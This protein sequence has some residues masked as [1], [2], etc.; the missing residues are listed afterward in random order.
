LGVGWAAVGAGTFAR[1]LVVRVAHSAG[2]ER[3]GFARAAHGD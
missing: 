1:R 3:H 2:Q